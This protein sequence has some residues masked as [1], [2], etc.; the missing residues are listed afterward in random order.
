[1]FPG[2]ETGEVKF[3]PGSWLA[4]GWRGGMCGAEW[5]ASSG[6]PGEVS[7]GDG[8]W[9]VT[10]CARQKFNFGSHLASS[11]W[12]TEWARGGQTDFDVGQGNRLRGGRLWVWRGQSIEMVEVEVRGLFR[13]V[14]RVWAFLGHT[15][16]LNSKCTFRLMIAMIKTRREGSR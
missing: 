13:I 4:G 9:S 8:A 14:R 6:C 7:G 16:F 3:R 12:C 5:I 11:S 10:E 15:T 2:M 1:V